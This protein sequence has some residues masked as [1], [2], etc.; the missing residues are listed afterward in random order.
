MI[1]KLVEI[2]L[3]LRFLFIRIYTPKMCSL[4]KIENHSPWVNFPHFR[5]KRTFSHLNW[6]SSAHAGE[7]IHACKICYLKW[8]VRMVWKTFIIWCWTIQNNSDALVA[9]HP[10]WKNENNSAWV[11]FNSL[12][13]IK[14]TFSNSVIFNL[15]FKRI[16]YKFLWYT[17]SLRIEI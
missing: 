2:L 11:N 5:E 16:I 6:W 14:L 10:K 7:F 3:I 13:L 8:K 17:H 12:T 4:L 9:T 15:V 1:N